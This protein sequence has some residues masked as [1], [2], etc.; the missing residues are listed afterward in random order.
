MVRDGA[1]CTED[2]A[3]QD[4]TVGWFMENGEGSLCG[5]GKRDNDRAGEIKSGPVLTMQVDTDA[6][7][8]TLWV[9]GKPHSPGYTSR[10]TGPLRRATIVSFMDNTVK[11]MPTPELQP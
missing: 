4:S 9:D 6:G 1:P 10:V 7:T 2:H 11:I 3:H 5:N 8:F